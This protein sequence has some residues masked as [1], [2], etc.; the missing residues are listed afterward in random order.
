M[1]KIKDMEHLQSIFPDMEKDIIELVYQQNSMSVDLTVNDLLAMSAPPPEPKLKKDELHQENNRQKKVTDALFV[2]NTQEAGE[3]SSSSSSGAV[4]PK[5]PLKTE[6][7]Y[8]NPPTSPEE[9]QI[10]EDERLAKRLQEREVERFHNEEVA[11]DIEEKMGLT[12][13]NDNC[14]STTILLNLTS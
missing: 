5:E 8:D 9:L 10:M 1:D 14:T 6:H 13:D 7:Y 11:R 3:A 12:G 4:L 2:G